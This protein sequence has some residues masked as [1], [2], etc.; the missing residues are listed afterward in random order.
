[1][2]LWPVQRPY[3]IHGKEI[4]KITMKKNLT[5]VFFVFASIVFFGL[6]AKADTFNNNLYYGLRNNTDVSQLQ[7][8][9]TT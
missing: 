7:E 2:D 6:V 5:T 9:L 4:K 3:L 1:M 8:F